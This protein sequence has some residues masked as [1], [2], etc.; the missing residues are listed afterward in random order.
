[1][2]DSSSREGRKRRVD[3]DQVRHSE[4]PHKRQNTGWRQSRDRSNLIPP[5]LESPD[6]EEEDVDGD[7]PG[8]GVLGYQKKAIWRQMQHYKR[9]YAS[10]VEKNATLTERIRHW[11]RSIITVSTFM[12]KVFE[13][14]R[15]FWERIPSTALSEPPQG[16]EVSELVTLLATPTSYPEDIDKGLQEKLLSVEEILR[17]LLNRID[18]VADTSNSGSNETELQLRVERRKVDRLQAECSRLE[19]ERNNAQGSL[20]V[21]QRDIVDLRQ[22]L[23]VKSEELSRLERKLDR[24]R[25]DA[26]HGLN[27]ATRESNSPEKDNGPPNSKVDENVEAAITAANVRLA[28]LHTLKRERTELVQQ[29]DQLRLQIANNTVTED[30]IR[31]SYQYRNLEEEYRYHV[32]DNVMLKRKL[33]SLTK[34]IEDLKA[35]RRKYAEDLEAEENS[36]RKTLENEMRK[37]EADL[38]RIRGLRDSLQQSLDL[39][40]S[41]DDIELTHV[42]EIR[43]LANNRLH[44]IVTL[45]AEVQ[46]LKM[47]M[48]AE[49][50]DRALLQYFDESSEENPLEDL[51]RKLNAADTKIKSLEE[52]IESL[53]TDPKSADPQEQDVRHVEAHE[54]STTEDRALLGESANPDKAHLVM[55]LQEQEETIIKLRVKI[56]FYEKSETRLLS[57]IE[58]IGKAWSE[59]EGR[60]SAKVVDLT[61]K[62]EQLL[63][64]VAEKTK[65]EQKCAAYAREKTAH[66]NVSIALKRQSDKQLEQI[67][68]LD[69][70]EKNLS[71]QLQAL[72]KELA[73]KNVLCDDHRRKIAEHIREITD[74]KEKQKQ[75]MTRYQNA[76]EI[77]KERS[78]ATERESEERRKAQEQLEYM[79]KKVEKLSKVEQVVDGNLTKQLEEY[80]LLL[81]CSSCN[82]KFK[83]HVL[84]KCMHT[85]W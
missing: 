10:E 12:G 60:S 53:R 40:S 72:E 77:L 56:E 37:L 34:E 49:T 47:R 19:T 18:R 61:K 71:Q 6:V 69:Q 22:Q 16:V 50:G 38:A 63:K 23:R 31:S 26:N 41:K 24:L 54:T 45:E 3:E 59:L 5:A 79:R 83:S 58:S 80:K 28:E 20:A 13:D 75:L 82:N 73:A 44:R 85:F 55:Q 36:R 14:L 46:R 48:A 42:E 68:L 27:G 70:K 67:R 30:A 11:D 7:I 32:D 52:M 29:I 21:Q 17:Q 66:G 74:L 81:K 76:A 84:L 25:T 9:L 78:E 15:R 1:M 33:E 65:L 57:E 8:S 51:R 4:H 43:A 64:L 2:S 62:E 39:R 35:D